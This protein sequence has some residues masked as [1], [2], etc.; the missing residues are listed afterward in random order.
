MKIT[1]NC[2]KSWTT[3]AGG[4]TRAQINL[5][6][7]DWPPVHGWKVRLIGTEITN[8][9]YQE[10]LAAKY[11]TSNKLQGLPRQCN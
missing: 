3:D 11:I 4:F 7:L 10:I 8:E 9:L 6:G 5:L 2:F 1:E